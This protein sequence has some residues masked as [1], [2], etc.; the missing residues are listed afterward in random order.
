QRPAD[1]RRAR[2][3]RREPEAAGVGLGRGQG[4]RLDGR[5]PGQGGRRQ[6]CLR[7]RG[8]LLGGGPLATTGV[9]HRPIRT[10]DRTL[11][12]GMVAEVWE[13]HDYIPRVFDDWVSD[14]GA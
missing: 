3:P 5:E 6:P 12:E 1:E 13:G 14:P 8:Q 7:P 2:M 9:E 10:S 4:P 11:V